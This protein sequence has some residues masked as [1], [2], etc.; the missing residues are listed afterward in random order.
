MLNELKIMHSALVRTLWFGLVWFS[1]IFYSCSVNTLS[2]SH[3]IRVIW[4]RSAHFDSHLVDPIVGII[5]GL[6]VLSHRLTFTMRNSLLL[7][8]VCQVFVFVFFFLYSTW[9]RLFRW[10]F[11]LFIEHRLAIYSTK[12]RLFDSVWVFTAY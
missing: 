2:I 9:T 10:Q 11:T 4:G 5:T 1:F 7:F 3:M 12:F 8:F 6:V